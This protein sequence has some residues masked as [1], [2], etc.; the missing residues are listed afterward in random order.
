MSL[1]KSTFGESLSHFVRSIDIVDTSTKNRLLGLIEEY[2]RDEL[3]IRFFTFY[4]ESSIDQKVGLVPTDWYRGGDRASFTIRDEEGS[5]RGQVSLAYDQAVPLWVVAS[6]KSVLRLA[7]DYLD[8]SSHVNN[9]DIP[10]YIKR[11]DYEILTSII[12]P[13]KDDKRIYGV[14]N[15]ES[16]KDLDYSRAAVD[17]LIEISESI[18]TLFLL[19][20]AYESQKRNTEREIEYLSKLS[21][22]R[23]NRR[24]IAKPKVFIASSS[25]A[26]D[27]VLSSILEVLHRYDE[28]IDIVYWQDISESG[29]IT[30]QILKEIRSCQYGVCYLSEPT[31]K[32]SEHLY[33]YNDNVLIEAGM[34]SAMSHENDFDNWI[35]IREK[36]SGPL[37]FDFANTRTITVP[38][39]KKEN[40]L[41]QQSFELE[42]EKSFLNWLES[43]SQKES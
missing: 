36:D 12:R 3:D 14:V 40:A 33:R 21:N 20:K 32:E 37:P 28:M 39:F 43:S 11:T 1:R 2:L 7:E 17:E 31:E 42:F 15:F 34:L 19:N 35:P 18:S 23:D 25:K 4:V 13:V 16:T 27:D 41:N 5:Y 22:N 24:R 30:K 26:E 29:M 9:S 8:L 38:R 10:K 6:D